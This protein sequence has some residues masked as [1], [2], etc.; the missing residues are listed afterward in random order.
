M[1]RSQSL[2]AMDPNARD[3]G[4]PM[5][6]VSSAPYKAGP[7]SSNVATIEPPGPN[8]SGPM[9]QF[10]SD[11]SLQFNTPILTGAYNIQSLPQLQLP[12]SVQQN[13]QGIG[14]A[15]S[16]GFFPADSLQQ[17]HH[18]N[19]IPRHGSQNQPFQSVTATCQHQHQS[20]YDMSNSDSKDS[21]LREPYAS[22]MAYSNYGNPPSAWAP[23]VKLDF[24]VAGGGSP[25]QMIRPHENKRPRFSQSISAPV[26]DVV[27]L[28]SLPTNTSYLSPTEAR[29]QAFPRSRKLPGSHSP[30]S[31]SSRLV[32]NSRSSLP[33]LTPH[34]L[35]LGLTK[36]TKSEE[37]DV[38]DGSAGEER[39]E[40]SDAEAEGRGEV[41]CQDEEEEP[42][43]CSAASS[44]RCSTSAGIGADAAPV[45]PVFDFSKLEQQTPARPTG[46]RATARSAYDSP[47]NGDTHCEGGLR[48]DAS[49]QLDP[50]D[51]FSS[52]MVSRSDVD[53]SVY[54]G[55]FAPMSI[56]RSSNLRKHNHS[57]VSSSGGSVSHW[58]T[59]QTPSDLSHYG[60]SDFGEGIGHSSIPSPGIIGRG[61]FDS[62]QHTSLSKSLGLA[63]SGTGEVDDCLAG[64]LGPSWDVNQS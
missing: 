48:N 43:V 29:D 9:S 6:R 61:F 53:S 54:R 5:A 44:T 47:M 27:Q 39:S 52:P 25:P 45:A 60:R 28:A 46:L 31:T 36:Q 57:T 24:S 63:P 55:S 4:K 26:V 42:P 59:L 19:S 33:T 14:R 56:S 64:F 20:M 3:L 34:T 7:Y 12:S 11:W 49:R 10:M 16:E 51:L 1:E 30:A 32:G 8:N 58:S 38:D 23:S 50:M 22:Q 18:P 37:L 21:S 2:Q 62:P 17:A 41:E 13:F 15:V 35:P 40:T